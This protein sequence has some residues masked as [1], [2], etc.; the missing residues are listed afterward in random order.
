MGEEDPASWGSPVSDSARRSGQWFYF[1]GPA[2]VLGQ[3]DV[4]RR[5]STDFVAALH[6]QCWLDTYCASAFA[7]ASRNVGSSGVTRGDG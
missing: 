1:L 6:A 7:I 4:P 3:I 5:R 2:N